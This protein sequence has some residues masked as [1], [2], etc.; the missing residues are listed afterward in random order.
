M[1]V[2]RSLWTGDLR[3]NWPGPVRGSCELASTAYVSFGQGIKRL[4]LILAPHRRKMGTVARP[5]PSM[6][7]SFTMCKPGSWT[8]RAPNL[9]ELCHVL[10]PWFL[11]SYASL[12]SLFYTFLTPGPPESPALPFL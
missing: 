8:T 4:E 9:S 2:G 1:S 6:C 11:S 5:F 3:L 10:V 7:L 12:V